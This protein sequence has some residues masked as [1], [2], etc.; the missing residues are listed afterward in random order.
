M[1]ASTN[2]CDITV[3]D[4]SGLRLERRSV[5][6]DDRGAGRRGPGWGE[7]EAMAVRSVCA[8]WRRQYKAWGLHISNVYGE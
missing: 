5:K 4:R 3:N 2:Q 6:K 8:M 1:C 7:R